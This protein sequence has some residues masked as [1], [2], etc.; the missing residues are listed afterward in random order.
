MNQSLRT[1]LFSA[2]GLLLLAGAAL[3]ITNASIAPY[4]F[5][6]GAAG[7][8]VCHLTTPV[9]H[10]EMRLRRLQTF[11]VV[12]GLLMVVASVFMFRRQTEWIL[13]LTIAAILQLYTTF[14]V[15]R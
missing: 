2:A 6:L 9:K 8:A 15:K 11:N 3:Y 5:A 10:L 14:A 4:L 13:C 12:A 7:I 1:T